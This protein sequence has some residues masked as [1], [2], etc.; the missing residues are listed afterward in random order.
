MPPKKKAKPEVSGD[1]L[2]LSGFPYGPSPMLY[3]TN[4]EAWY[5]VK[6]IDTKAEQVKVRCNWAG[7]DLALHRLTEA[8]RAVGPRAAGSRR[9]GRVSGGARVEAPLLSN[10]FPGWPKF[11][12]HSASVERNRLFTCL[13]TNV[14]VRVTRRRRTAVDLARVDLTRPSTLPAHRFLLATDHIP[15]L[16]V[17]V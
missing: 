14:H 2:D 7:A 10:N 11:K 9:P 16:V 8:C 5:R 12:G 13:L 1:G 3:D 6:V 15:R 4:Y 17:V